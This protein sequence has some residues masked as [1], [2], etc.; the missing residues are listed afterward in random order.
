MPLN[1]D[2]L[3]SVAAV[4][5]VL[6]RTDRTQGFSADDQEQYDWIEDLINAVS[7]AIASYC[8]RQFTPERT[9]PLLT[10]PLAPASAKEFEYSYSGY[11][12]FAPWEPRSISEVRLGSELPDAEHRIL[13]APPAAASEYRP[14]PSQKTKLGTYL[15]L[16]LPERGYLRSQAV[17]TSFGTQV[18]VTGEWGALTV[19][20]DVEF[21]CKAE[22]ARSF[23]NPEGYSSRR[24]GGVEISLPPEGGGILL[25]EDAER[26]LEAWDRKR[27]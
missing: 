7:A 1:A 4:E 13:V 25:S 3:T 27:G 12:S 17:N 8:D 9:G 15:W 5:R 18:R 26:A 22:V 10:D 23:R 20:G 16:A 2:A 14:R 11:L 6:D 19:P 24:V 21:I